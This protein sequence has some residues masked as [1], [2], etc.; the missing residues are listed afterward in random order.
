MTRVVTADAEALDTAAAAGVELA[1]RLRTDAHALGAVLDRVRSAPSEVALSVPALDRHLEL[2]AAQWGELA[3]DVGRVAA[4][5][6]A[7]DDSVFGWLRLRLLLAAVA[8]E[9][10]HVDRPWHVDARRVDAAVARV[11]AALDPG[12]WG[13]RGDDLATIR[14]TLA[15]LSGPEADAVLGALSDDE[16][17]GWVGQM[18]NGWLQGGWSATQRHELFVVVG[19]KVSLS[20][21]RR[22]GRFTDEIDPPLQGLVADGASPDPERTAWFEALEYQPADGVLVAIGPEDAAPFAHDDLRQGAIG[23]CYLVAAM[24]ALG[25][26]DPAALADLVRPN[27][28]GTFTVTFGDGE[29]VVVSADLPTHPDEDRVAF[30]RRAD[31]ADGADGGR[32]LWPML[33]EK[34]VAQRAGGWAAIVGGSQSEAIERLTGRRS[35]WIDRGDVSVADLADR[36]DEGQILGLSTIDAPGGVD[37]D[38]WLA[39]EAPEPFTRGETRWDRLHQDHAFVVTAVDVAAGTVSVVNPWDPTKGPVVLTEDELRASVD[40]IRVNGPRP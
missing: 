34:A 9:R 32:E 21:W 40:G 4:A 18:H 33:V 11:R 30:A 5:F 27:P 26:H 15:G 1:D 20:T 19:E 12:G 3:D 35:G 17:A 25:R 36:M 14:D 16:L 8:I 39:S 37:H 13:V 28:N 22:L 2:V 38:E 24:Q 23:D 7:V 29:R 10:R 6:R 31:G